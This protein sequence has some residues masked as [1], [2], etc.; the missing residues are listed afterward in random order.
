MTDP[1]CCVFDVDGVVIRG[2]ARD[3]RLWTTDLEKDL[4][5]PP[6]ELVRTF[7]EG[8]FAD[9]LRGK[10]PLEE[11]LG[12]AMKEMGQG[13]KT[14]A[15][16]EYWL[17]HDDG[18][19]KELISFLDR[20]REEHDLRLILATNQEHRRAKYIW[21]DLHLSDHFDRVVYSA[22]IGH[23]KSEEAFFEVLEKSLQHNCSKRL[24]IDDD[25]ANI[26]I[27][28]KRGWECHLFQGTETLIEWL[29]AR[30][31]C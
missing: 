22:A 9:A 2:R 17:R 5:I 31:G 4:G 27:A 10:R 24:Y 20:Q 16:I 1:I 26:A 3:H 8:K 18:I 30:L 29:N 12:E 19:D 25:A 21:E 23:L 14:E 28:T 7:F 15:L 13:G 11:V 6:R